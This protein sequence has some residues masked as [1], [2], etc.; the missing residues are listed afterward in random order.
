MHPQATSTHEPDNGRGGKI[1]ASAVILGGGR[2][3]R[4]GGNKLFLSFQG[5]LVLERVLLRLA[6]YFEAVLLSVGSEDR[7]PLEKLLQGIS[8]PFSLK[9]VED[10]A[11]GKGPLEGLARSL[12]EL[13]TEWGFFVGCDMPW[14]QEMVVRTLWKARQKNSQAL[15][16]RRGEYLEPLH[17]FYARSCLSS[18]EKVLREGKR[19]MK[20][21]YAA[22]ELTVVEESAFT[23]LPGYGRSFRGMNT[24]EDLQQFGDA[25]HI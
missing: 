20:S 14:I 24:P 21:F 3:R 8:L 6:P 9:I 25:Y 1:P 5:H 10:K 22:I 15:V 16:V 4:M 19:Q 2:G 17:A 11:S 18:V 12:E 13:P 23:L 7:E